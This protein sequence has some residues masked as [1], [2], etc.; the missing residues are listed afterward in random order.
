MGAKRIEYQIVGRYMNGKEVT[1]Y[2]LQSIDTGKSGKYTKEQVCFLV[3]RD[4]VTNC[5]A[6]LTADSIILRGNG[7]SLNELPVQYEDGTTK[8]MEQLGRI[9]HGASAQDAMAMFMLV[10]SIKQGRNTVGYVVQNAGCGIRKLKK[11]Q[12]IELA[13]QGKIGNA[14]VQM[15]QGKPLLRGVGCDLGDL[16]SENI[17]SAPVKEQQAT[18]KHHQNM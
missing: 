18:K 5:S 8:N 2:H 1:G 10:G 12:V 17:G 9:K 3:G 14:R 16:P 4:Q 6:Q 7:I 15:Y 11:Q 13:Q